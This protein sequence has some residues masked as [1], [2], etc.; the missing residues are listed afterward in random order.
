MTEIV[1]IPNRGHALTIDH[2]W[3]EVAQTALDF[4]K[5]FTSSPSLAVTGRRNAQRAPRCRDRSLSGTPSWR[6][7]LLSAAPASCSCCKRGRD[8]LSSRREPTPSFVYTLLRW[9]S[10]VRG[11]MKSSVPISG[12]VP[13][14]CRQ[15]GDLRFLRG[16]VGTRVERCA[17]GRS[18]RS[19]GARDGLARRR[20]PLPCRGTCRRRLEAASRASRRRFSRRSHSP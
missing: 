8:R 16:E 13:S 9:Y 15:A 18:R 4:V 12:L 5:R 10:T 20:P 17:G 2:G 3:R 6:R 11:L 1:K 7:R 19:R 14:L